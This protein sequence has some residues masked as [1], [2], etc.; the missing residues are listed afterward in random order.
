M[1]RNMSSFRLLLCGILILAAGF[2]LLAG[3]DQSAAPNYERLFRNFDPQLKAQVMT[4]ENLART[5][6]RWY[7]ATGGFTNPGLLKQGVTENVMQVAFFS[8]GGE[9]SVVG[10]SHTLILFEDGLSKLQDV[11]YSGNLDPDTD[12]IHGVASIHAEV[13]CPVSSDNDGCEGSILDYEEFWSAT[14]D[15]RKTLSGE[16]TSPIIPHLWAFDLKVK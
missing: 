4:D 10:Y 2:L 12:E 16:L 5:G 1:R 7:A 13:V 8:G 11:R 9:D 6:G 3:C 15:G 14:W